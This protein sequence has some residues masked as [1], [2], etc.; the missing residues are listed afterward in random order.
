MG[1]AV[2]A[3]YPKWVGHHEISTVKSACRIVTF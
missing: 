3:E 1:A 2:I